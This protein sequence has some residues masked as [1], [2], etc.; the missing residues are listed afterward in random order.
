MTETR[1]TGGLLE[2]LA[3]VCTFSR[4]DSI[5]LA[6]SYD[7]V[8]LTAKPGIHKQ[9]AQILQT[10]KLA[11]NKVFALA[12]TVI[13]PRDHNL[14]IVQI[15]GA[16]GIIQNQGYLRE[17]DLRPLHCSSEN[18][19]LHLSAAEI[20]CRLLA[21]HPQN[22][23]RYVGLPAAVGSDNSSNRLFKRQLR[24]FRE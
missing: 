11:V 19:V 13:P 18:D 7:A 1:N 4:Q 6:L 21:H 17:A 2:Y 24:L 14:S 16:V 3:P 10:D 23:V 8:T 9:L 5:D 15:K 12:G 20:P 22:G